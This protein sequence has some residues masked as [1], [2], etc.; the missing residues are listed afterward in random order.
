MFPAGQDAGTI[1]VVFSGM[2]RMRIF[3]L[4]LTFPHQGGR[5]ISREKAQ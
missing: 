4:I 1:R 5:D 2:F 3:T